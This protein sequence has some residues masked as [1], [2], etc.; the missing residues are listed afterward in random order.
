MEYTNHNTVKHYVDNNIKNFKYLMEFE[1]EDS[2]L[3]FTS[4]LIVWKFIKITK[5]LIVKP[6]LIFGT[7]NIKAS[8]ILLQAKNTNQ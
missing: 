7:L 1:I 5:N 3:E 2:C 8:N 4:F 6:N